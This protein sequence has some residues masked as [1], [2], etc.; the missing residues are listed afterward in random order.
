MNEKLVHKHLLLKAK[1]LNPPMKEEVLT[2]W[3]KELVEDIGMKVCIEPRAR[4]VDNPGNRG[5][6]GLV[7]IETSHCSMHV[8]DEM[9]PGIIQMDVYSCA[10]FV[11]ETVINKLNEFKIVDFEMMFID[12]EDGFKVLRHERSVL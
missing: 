10:E 2:K 11:P 12:R 1:V 7:G 4:Y 6:T 3:F 8:W 9:S 5:I